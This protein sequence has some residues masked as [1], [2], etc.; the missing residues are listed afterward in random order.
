MKEVGCVSIDTF[1]GV[2]NTVGVS[3]KRGGLG[4]A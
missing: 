1:R 3:K 4:E 2:V